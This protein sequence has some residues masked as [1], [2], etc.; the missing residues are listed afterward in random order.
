MESCPQCAG[1]RHFS[2]IGEGQ[3]AQ[4]P[5]E[6]VGLRGQPFAQFV[7]VPSG[8]L[9]PQGWTSHAFSMDQNICNESVL[10]QKLQAVRNLVAQ[11]WVGVLT[12]RGILPDEL[13]ALDIRLRGTLVMHKAICS[14][15]EL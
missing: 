2:P 9:N 12:N 1:L 8:H 10:L 6:P 7:L 13:L 14:E 3:G 4:Y 15:R 5:L 11:V